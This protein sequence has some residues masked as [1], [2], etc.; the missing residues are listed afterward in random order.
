MIAGPLESLARMGSLPTPLRDA[1]ALLLELVAGAPPADGSSSLGE[2]G[3]T[4][5]TA[6]AAPA[7][8]LPFEAHRRHIDLHYVLEGEEGYAC[9]GLDRL[10][11]RSPY[12]E[13]SDC[14][15]FEPSAENEDRLVLVPGWAVFFFPEDGHKPRCLFDRS[16]GTCAV[17]KVVVKIP[18]SKG[19]QWP[20]LKQR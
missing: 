13:A 18:A 10:R 20:E 3:M 14:E 2:Y 16:D 8:T 7:S 19:R 5:S 6:P 1:A 4:A 12:D 17:R 11:G 9:A 15:L